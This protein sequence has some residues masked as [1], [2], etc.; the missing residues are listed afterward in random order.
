MPDKGGAGWLYDSRLRGS[1]YRD[2][3][4]GRLISKSAAAEMRDRFIDGQKARIDG[5]TDKLVDGKI[6]IQQWTLEPRK[7]LAKTYAG[8]YAASKG[9]FANVTQAEWGKL[10][11]Q[12]KNEQYTRLDKLAQDIADGKLSPAQ[13]NA[14]SKLY[15]EG[16]SQVYERGKAE[17]QGVPDL[18]AYPGDGQTACLSNCRCNWSFEETE[19]A[20]EATWELNDAEHCADCLAN[21]E[22][23]NPLRLPK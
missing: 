10:G 6:N 5:L 15:V 23:W 8:E 16:A 11:A 22:Q 7:T 2:A 21:A 19:E 18:P 17:N 13:I 3:D 4:T 12:L 1:G 9:G 14:R 20:W